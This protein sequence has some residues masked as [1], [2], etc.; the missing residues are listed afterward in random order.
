MFTAIYSPTTSDKAS[1]R[2]HCVKIDKTAEQNQGVH[3]SHAPR[4]AI[5]NNTGSSST[6][7]TKSTIGHNVI[8]LLTVDHDSYIQILHI[9]TYLFVTSISNTSR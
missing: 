5:N 2:P 4:H 3:V 9:H 6:T 1:H 7:D 8:T